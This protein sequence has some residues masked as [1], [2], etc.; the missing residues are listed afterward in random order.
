M[1]LTHYKPGWDEM[2]W[3]AMSSFPVF[4]LLLLPTSHILTSSPIAHVI[5]LSSVCL[6]LPVIPGLEHLIH[7][8]LQVYP[9]GSLLVQLLSQGVH[10]CLFP[11]LPQ[12]FLWGKE[13]QQKHKFERKTIQ[14][15][16]APHKCSHGHESSPAFQPP[17]TSF[18]G[19]TN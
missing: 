3:S 13:T 16:E 12:L 7:L 2:L 4:P 10:I 19:K 15:K 9:L 1:H 6:S 5:A 11:Q 18:G 17:F 8:L 14:L